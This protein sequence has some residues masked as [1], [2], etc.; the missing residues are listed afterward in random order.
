MRIFLLSTLVFVC[1]MIPAKKMGSDNKYV[2]IYVSDKVVV[3]NNSPLSSHPELRNQSH[4]LCIS[5]DANGKGFEAVLNKVNSG[6]L[7]LQILPEGE[8][9]IIV[10]KVNQII[11]A[12]KVTAGSDIKLW[13][14]DNNNHLWKDSDS[15]GIAWKTQIS[16]PNLQNG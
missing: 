5:V 6:D 14:Q 2:I 13:S 12:K 1:L 8:R 11:L 10:I 4:E 3:S 9:M 16:N 7:P 15:G